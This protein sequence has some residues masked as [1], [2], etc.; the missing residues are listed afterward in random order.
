MIS[1]CKPRSTQ[2]L[3]VSIKAALKLEPPQKQKIPQTEWFFTFF[4]FLRSSCWRVQPAL[5][6]QSFW[7]SANSQSTFIS[8]IY[9]LLA[10]VCSEER[11]CIMLPNSLKKKHI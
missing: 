10:L 11:T 4:F 5:M 9:Q 7:K 6:K 8:V 2:T 1:E 3:R